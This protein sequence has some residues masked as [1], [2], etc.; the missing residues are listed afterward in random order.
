MAGFYQKLIYKK[1]RG[2][3]TEQNSQ[4]EGAVEAGQFVAKIIIPSTQAE[5]TS[6][7][8]AG[9]RMTGAQLPAGQAAAPLLGPQVA[10]IVRRSVSS[11][12]IIESA[13]TSPEE[14]ARESTERFISARQVTSMAS[15]EAR[16]S[17]PQALRQSFARKIPLPNR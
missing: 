17:A 5:P 11:G 8:P 4:A 12:E 16:C 3:F 13:L 6:Y 15:Q 7:A 9:A 2:L 1:I 14:L 10:E